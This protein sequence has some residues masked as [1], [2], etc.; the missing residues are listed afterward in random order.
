MTFDSSENRPLNDRDYAEVETALQAAV[1]HSSTRR[2]LLDRAG[3][4][5]AVVGTGAVLGA[6]SPA[7]AS[8]G[9]ADTASRR[10][11]TAHAIKTALATFEVFG[12]TFGSEAVR[13]APGTPSEAFL[14]VLKSANQS[15]YYHLR[16]LQ[17]IDAE[18]IAKRIW[19]PEAL[20]G[21]GGAGLFKSIEHDEDIEISAYLVG[22]TTFARQRDAAGA[23]LCAEA[24]GTEAVHRALA[25]DAQM[26]LGSPIDLAPNDRGFERFYYHSGGSA[27]AALEALGVGF[28]KA[29]SAPGAFYEFPGNPLDSGVG[30]TLKSV[31]P[32]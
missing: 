21:A 26:L 20:F 29:T 19:I 25:R 15:E 6:A 12:V 28:G 22:V 3:K 18:P 32:R 1:P 24:L 23:R 4:A 8:Q 9:D 27:L 31:R 13:R 11:D 5:L 30:A 16:A 17:R 2:A 14:P 10:A 7:F